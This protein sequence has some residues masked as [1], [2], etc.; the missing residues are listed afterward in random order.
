[1]TGADLRRGAVPASILYS[2]AQEPE[3]MVKARRADADL[4]LVDL[5]DS[6]PPSERLV[7][8]EAVV[9][10]LKEPIDLARTAVRINPLSTADYCADVTMLLEQEA[11]PGFVFMTMVED[12]AEVTCLRRALAGGGWRPQIY[13]TI[14]TVASLR[15]VHA[16]SAV[17]DGMILGSAD[18]AAAMGI[19][20]SD[21]GLRAAREAMALAAAGTGAGCIDTGNFRLD[22]VEALAGEIAEAKALGFHGKGTV[23]PRELAAINAAFR[24]D[25]ETTHQ[26]RRVCEAYEAAAGGVCVLDGRM[27]GPPFARLAEERLRR[28]EAWAAAFGLEG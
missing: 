5:E 28:A 2:S 10:Y 22:D 26:A 17:L 23:H 9:A 21:F 25:P 1:M 3:K 27:I 18:L 13:A 7:A 16:L 24:P 8:R 11:R 19:E 4:Y 15:N 12:P 6:V 20:I 14:E